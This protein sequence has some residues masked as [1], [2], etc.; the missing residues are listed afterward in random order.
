MVVD[1]SETR[2]E[3]SNN[4]SGIWAAVWHGPASYELGFEVWQGENGRKYQINSMLD[5]GQICFHGGDPLSVSSGLESIA[6]LVKKCCRPFIRGDPSAFSKMEERDAGDAKKFT[7]EIVLRPL[8]IQAEEAWSAKDYPRYCEIAEKIGC[9]LT[10]AERR[11][12][13]VAKSRR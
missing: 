12:L 13:S 1:E 7:D 4:Q 8:R 10:N 5:D 11:R 2:V 6:D 3:Y 9:G